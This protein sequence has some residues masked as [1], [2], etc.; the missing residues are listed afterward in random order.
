MLNSAT[1]WHSTYPALPIWIDEMNVNADW[2]ND[3]H[4]RP[5]GP[6]AAA[7]WA[8]TYA[9]L[10]PLNVAMLGH[11]NVVESA[12]FGLIDYDTG[13]PYLPYWVVKTLNTAFPTGSTRLQTASPDTKKIE[14]MAARRPDGKISVL[15]AD[16]QVDAAN[17]RAGLGLAEDVNVQ[18]NGIVPNAVSLQQVDTNTSVTAGPSTSALTP[19]TTL[20]V[21]FPG[22]GLAIL[23]I[24]P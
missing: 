8:S 12:Q 13:N 20:S 14:V 15:V 10:A 21:H 23:T 19:S 6:F 9:E 5:W 18:L 22:Y 1:N 3:P 7:W 2:G 11:Y 24:T 16:R 4:G 17:P